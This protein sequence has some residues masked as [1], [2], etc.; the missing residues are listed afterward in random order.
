MAP[1]GERAPIWDPYA[2]GV[3]FGINLNHN[4]GNFVRAIMEAAAYAL[5]N[6]I[7]IAEKNGISIKDIRA[8]GGHARSNLWLQIKADVTG[9]ILY[10]TNFSQEITVLGASILA[11]VGAGQYTDPVSASKKITKV[12]R[13]IKPNLEKHKK[14]IRYF[15]LYKKLYVNLKD[16]YR[17]LYHI[18]SEKPQ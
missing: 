2:K 3:L 8:S 11:G 5:L 4:K 9:K 12:T 14:Y 7:E 17:D 6:N 18:L 10:L 16:C 1:N 13:K 15:E